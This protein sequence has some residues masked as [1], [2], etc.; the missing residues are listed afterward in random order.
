M[1]WRGRKSETAALTRRGSWERV[2]HVC[3]CGWLGEKEEAVERIGEREET[4]E[5]TVERKTAAEGENEECAK[6]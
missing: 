4:V 5:K 6:D 1:R 2:S 3:S